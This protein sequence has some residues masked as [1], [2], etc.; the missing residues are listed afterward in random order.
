MPAL[1]LTPRATSPPSCARSTHPTSRA[2][3]AAGIHVEDLTGRAR[4][5][6]CRPMHDP[7]GVDH[8]PGFDS[9]ESII[10]PL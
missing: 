5:R 8:L 2:S 4:S 1:E 9:R 6:R 7:G 3:R 10:F